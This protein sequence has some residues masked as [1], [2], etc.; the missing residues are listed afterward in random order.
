MGQER[1]VTSLL[2]SEVPFARRRRKTA[3]GWGGVLGRRRS[4]YMLSLAAM[5][6]VLF[7]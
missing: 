6:V 7:G 4:P 5:A 2:T 1:S 3:V